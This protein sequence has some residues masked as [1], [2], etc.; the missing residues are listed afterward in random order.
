[1]KEV[2]AQEFDERT[3]QALR[4]KL[5]SNCSVTSGNIVML[6]PVYGRSGVLEKGGEI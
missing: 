3:K 4:I 5:C 2:T 6:A 1:M